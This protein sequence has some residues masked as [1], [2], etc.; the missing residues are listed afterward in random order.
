MIGLNILYVSGKV[1]KLKREGASP[2]DLYVLF[3]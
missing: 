2:L 3:V 1:G